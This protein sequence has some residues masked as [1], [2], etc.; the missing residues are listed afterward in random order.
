MPLEVRSANLNE[1]PVLGILHTI[2]FHR[3]FP[4][5]LPQTR[6]VLDLTLPHVADV[7]LETLID[8]R[9]TAL[10]R[11]LDAERH[12]PHHP[13]PSTGNGSGRG[14]IEV[15]FFERRRRKPAWY[16]V[17]GDEEICWESWTVKVT[18]AEP[19]TESGELFLFLGLFALISSRLVR[20]ERLSRGDMLVA[21]ENKLNSTSC[22][23]YLSFSLSY[24]LT[25]SVCVS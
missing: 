12:Q 18:V 24:L 7:E 17:R 9:T 20:G 3:F 11:Q 6:E 13:G 4:S 16:A 23:P 8:Q 14:Q 25:A 2:F 10:I 5:I 19:R 15:Q 1:Q 21:L 22:L